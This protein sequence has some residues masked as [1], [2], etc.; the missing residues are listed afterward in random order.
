MLS[1]ALFKIA[2]AW[3]SQGGRRDSGA[4]QTDGGN[5]SAWPTYKIIFNE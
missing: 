5:R 2:G 1:V 3:E 4:M